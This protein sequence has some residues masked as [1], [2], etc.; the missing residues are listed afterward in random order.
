MMGNNQCGNVS[1]FH[2]TLLAN[3]SLPEDE[4]LDLGTL[5]FHCFRDIAE[6]K[7]LTPLT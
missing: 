6:G 4:L 3:S 1:R 5:Q 2:E 7:D